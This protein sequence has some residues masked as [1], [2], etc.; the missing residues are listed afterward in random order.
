MTSGWSPSFFSIQVLPSDLK[1]EATERLRAFVAYHDAQP[2]RRWSGRYLDRFRDNL[3]G[4][5]THMMAA[6]LSAELPAFV[7]G[8][9]VYDRHRGQDVRTVRPE[10]SRLF[11]LPV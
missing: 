9:A 5:L 10:L 11:D 2:H 6:D 8:K 7:R 1:R 4:V 3:E